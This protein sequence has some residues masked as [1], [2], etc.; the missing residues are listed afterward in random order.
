MAKVLRCSD[1]VPGCNY[2]TRGQTSEEVFTRAAEH[3]RLKH[4]VREVS[5]EVTAVIH[6][7]IFDEDSSHPDSNLRDGAAG[8]AWWPAAQH[9]YS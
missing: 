4:K 7:V 6:G 5:P 1:I 9:W 2:V 3:V 8:Q